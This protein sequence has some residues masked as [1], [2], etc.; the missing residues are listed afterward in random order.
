VIDPPGI[1]CPNSVTTD[2]PDD[3][4]VSVVFTFPVATNG[5][6]PVTVT[7]TAQPGA[8]FPVGS[9][10]VTCTARDNASRESVCSF[11]VTVRAVPKLSKTSFLAFGDS[12]T[13]GVDSA[14]LPS[15]LFSLGDSWSYPYQ[16]NDLLLARYATQSITL[17]NVGV[18]GETASAA[19]APAD[20]RS[21]GESRFRSELQR[22][23][24]EVVFIMEGTNDLFFGDD[25]ALV[26]GIAALDRMV[27][28][29]Q[30][31]GTRVF[32]ATIPPQRSGGIRRRDQWAAQVPGFNNEVKALA[33]RK[34]V[35]LVD[36]YSA[37]NA[38]L[39][40]YLGDDDV[41]PTVAGFR[42]IADT[43]MASIKANLETTTQAQRVR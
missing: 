43:F 11:G 5:T 26:Y 37:I 14:P 28:E 16:L 18:G 22:Y 25:A 19:L 42:V 3:K 30:S 23:R 39:R 41:H 2:S 15:L 27:T 13:F 8:A 4:P 20:G 12:I 36:V 34:G 21:N 1:V 32:L 6:P 9:T 24:P 10:T 29:A 40:R 33:T 7:C 31:Q 17:N 38:D 35:V